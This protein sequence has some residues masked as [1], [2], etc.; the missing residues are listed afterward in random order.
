M[1]VTARMVND[2]NETVFEQRTPFGP[3]RFV[4][5][6]GRLS[7]D[8]PLARLPPGEY[9]LTIGATL[10]RHEAKRDVRFSVK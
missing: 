5:S 6:I 8:L 2:R 10:A 1:S 9:L 3:E 7:I 4:R